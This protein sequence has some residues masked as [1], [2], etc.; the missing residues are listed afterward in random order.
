MIEHKYVHTYLYILLISKDSIVI[1]KDNKWFN[2][3]HYLHNSSECAALVSIATKR[4]RIYPVFYECCGKNTWNSPVYWDC[5]QWHLCTLR[6][7]DDNSNEDFKKEAWHDEN[8]RLGFMNMMEFRRNLY[9]A[10][11][12]RNDYD[13]VVADGQ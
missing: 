6:A 8:Y 3:F 11:Q 5:M 2:S 7:L 4:H 1:S 13:V 10:H 12:F 9:C